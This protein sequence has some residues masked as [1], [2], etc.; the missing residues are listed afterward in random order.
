MRLLVDTHVLL[1]A[2]DSPEKLSAAARGAL[3]AE[4][5]AVSVSMASLWEVAIKLSLG[6]ITLAPDWFAM[7]EAGRVRIGAR[8]LSV[9]AV[10]CREAAVLPWHHR[11]PFDRLLVAQAMCEDMTLVSRDRVLADYPAPVLW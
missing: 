9:E 6:R 10:H 2:V 3:L 11:D 5:N 1:W 4:D 8:W 7:I